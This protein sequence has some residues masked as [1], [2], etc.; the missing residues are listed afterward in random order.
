MKE[1]VSE[2]FKS[3]KIVLGFILL[4]VVVVILLLGAF[5][6]N[7][8][9]YKHSYSEVENIMVSAARNHMA[10]NENI[11][12]NNYNEVLNVSVNDLVN[13]GE[14]KNIDDYFRDSSIS[15]MGNVNI[16]NINNMYRYVPVLDCGTSYKTEKLVDYIK[17]HHPIVDSGNGLY[18]MNDELVFRGDLV[19]N[20]LK[21]SGKIYRIVKI[22]DDSVVV[23]LDERLESK[24]WDDRY[25][26]EKKSN[27]GINNYAVS[28]IRDYLE[29]QYKGTNLLGVDEDT[30][31]DYKT[32]VIAHNLEIGKRKDMESD[33]TGNVERNAIMENHFIGLLPLYDYMNASLDANCDN[34]IAPSC[35]NYN[36]LAKFERNWWTM[37]GVDNNTFSVY[38]ISSS[39][40]MSSAK[41]NGYVRPV[42]HLAK[43]VLYVSGN[44]TSE[45]PYI[46]K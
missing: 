18:N 20:F 38:K 13:A 43:D 34:S 24:V 12:P 11:L 8:I 37:T 22:K 30:K 44:G 5:F 1:K 10:K 46:V 33:K 29:E 36:Y 14:M 40:S 26:K 21:L 19:N 2:L 25:N 4:I 32:L 45:E 15:C 17:Q 28:I 6:Y 3:K 9:F 7:K 39:P 23:I 35:M 42:F 27:K 41:S 31:L 16:T